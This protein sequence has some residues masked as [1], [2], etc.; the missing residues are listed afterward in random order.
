CDAAEFEAA[1]ARGDLSRAL[2]VYRGEFLAGFHVA[3][4]PE[5]Q[6][7]LDR[8]RTRFRDLAAQAARKL[9]DDA[10]SLDR[11]DD[12][13]R[14]ARRSLLLDPHDESGLRRLMTLLDTAGDRAAALRA[15]DEFARRLMTELDLEPS[16]ETR[17]IRERV[18]RLGARDSGANVSSS[19]IQTATTRDPRP[20]TLDT[21][22][23]AVLPFAIRGDPAL[24]WL[25]EGIV[26][27]LAT[28]LDGAG[29]V[30]A[31][32]PR[33]LL[34]LVQ[35]EGW[36]EQDPAS[37]ATI[38]HQVGAGRYVLG[39]LVSA[40]GRLQATA[41]LY[42]GRGEQ[43]LSVQATA[44]GEG[45]VFDLV[46]EL[47]RQLLAAGQAGPGARLSRL[48]AR[49]TTS[50]PALKA[51]LVGEGHIRAGRYYDAMESLQDAV[52]ADPTFAL[53]YYRFAAAAGG[54]AMPE[55]ARQLAELGAEH[56]NRLSEHD[57]Y[58]FDAQRAWLSG[59]VTEAEA[60][61]ATITSI[62]PGDVEAW[63][64]L[65][66]LLFHSNPLRGRS[67]TEARG[68]FERA[69][70][71]E[72]DHVTS[73]VH[74]VRIAAL[75]GNRDEA[76]ERASRV[77]EL[78][79]E[80]DEVLAMR[81]F[82]AYATGNGEEIAAVVEA[83]RSARLAA[84]ALAFTDVAVY[85]G[86][87][88]AAESLARELTGVA[89]SDEMRALFHVLLAHLALARKAPDAALAELGTAEKLD[90][91]WGLETRALFAALPFGGI[92]Q[93]EAVAARDALLAWDASRA[94]ASSFIIFAMHNDLHP[95]IRLYLL[96][97]VESRLGDLRSA[98]AHAEALIALTP[99]PGAE[100]ISHHLTRGALARVLWAEGK[101]EEA[102]AELGRG[103]TEAWFL[104]TVA[105]PFYSQAFERWMRAELLTELGRDD[106]ADGWRDSIAERS[107]YEIIYR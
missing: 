9:A 44:G 99:V 40:G 53:A 18:A 90:R 33:A 69:L 10:A 23:I 17:E 29:A 57:R 38:A 74:L 97:L 94:E 8:E 36:Q 19:A 88:V 41:G 45:E 48:A 77:I 68:A 80:G 100:A 83:L 14:Y 3:G 34:R 75:E 63:F 106:E 81:A 104:L 62:Y 86:D 67:A 61:Y 31:A 7:W 52:T 6:D 102:L 50:M 85:A 15:Y 78:S 93:E 96:A 5:Y 39:S 28:A 105:S 37:A 46:D 66:D 32:D 103:Q 72:P 64:L 76:L 101:P 12:A 11:H 70:A 65:G 82:R 47:A 54:C 2:D 4:A 27:L 16:R 25:G 26:D 87:L 95:H 55:L 79:P 21:S 13:I 71:L 107:P 59:A 35:R 56:R 49:T 20:E 58:L 22:T 60:H 1:V 30:R 73:L 43:E 42:D 84:I 24:A 92:P 51:Y 98:R 89:R 91:A